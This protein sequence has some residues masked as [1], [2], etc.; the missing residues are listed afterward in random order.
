MRA[1]P[2]T[3]T[4]PPSHPRTNP[5]RAP[6]PTKAPPSPPRPN[7]PD[8]ARDG[9]TRPAAPPTPRK[10]AA[11]RRHFHDH[12]DLLTTHLRT[13]S[14]RTCPDLRVRKRQHSPHS[15]SVTAAD[16]V[17]VRNRRSAWCH[18]HDQVDLS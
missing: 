1:P 3:T 12:R 7:P 2:P 13:V 18:L 14:C 8:H 4:P 11:G 5:M 17:R 9:A 6:P 16:G 15:P 10:P